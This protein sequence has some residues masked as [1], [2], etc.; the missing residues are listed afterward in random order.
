MVCLGESRNV[1]GLIWKSLRYCTQWV[2][3]GCS[4]YL[5]DASTAGCCYA[6]LEEKLGYCKAVGNSVGVPGRWWGCCGKVYKKLD[7]P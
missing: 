7:M 1:H 2:V 6:L 3:G 5:A 4:L